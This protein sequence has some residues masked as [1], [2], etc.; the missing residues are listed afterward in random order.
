M[1][2][3]GDVARSLYEPASLS[4]FREL[5]HKLKDFRETVDSMGGFREIQRKIQDLS[6]LTS[7]TRS[8]D[9]KENLVHTNSLEQ[10]T[11]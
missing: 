4:N 11:Q 3:F 7:F 6:E 10:A 9:S 8:K 2:N 1:T 5:S